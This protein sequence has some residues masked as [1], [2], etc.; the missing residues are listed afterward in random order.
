MIGKW[1]MLTSQSI[2]K[3]PAVDLKSNHIGE[4]PNAVPLTTYIIHGTIVM[5]N[6]EERP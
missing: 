2:K 4:T 5:D 6:T 3:I 1:R